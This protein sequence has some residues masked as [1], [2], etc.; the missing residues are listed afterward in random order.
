[1]TA[2]PDQTV[3][4]KEIAYYAARAKGGVGLIVNEVTRV[5]D[6]HGM[7]GDRQTSVTDD[8]LFRPQK[9]CRCSSL[10]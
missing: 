4:D 3:S 6:E 5:N 10:L 2:N 8:S 1:M 9:T 7:M